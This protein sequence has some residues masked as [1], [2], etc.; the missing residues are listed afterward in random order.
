MTDAAIAL[1]PGA[2]LDRYTIESQ[3]SG[4]GFSIVYVA[5][6]QDGG[7]VAI[8]EYFPYRLAERSSGTQVVVTP[9]NQGAFNAGLNA[10]FA[11]ARVLAEIDHPNV[12]RVLGVFRANGTAYMVMR[13]EQ[14]RTLQE[15]L[16]QLAAE[17]K[18][19]REPSLRQVFSLLLAGLREVHRHRLLHLDIKPANILLRNDGQPVLLD[20]GAT[21][22]AL[23]TGATRLVPV[24][25]PGYAAPEQQGSGEP[26]G[27]WTDIYAIGATLYACMA[28]QPP[29]PAAQRLTN[30]C[31]VP[32]ADQ[33]ADRYSAQLLE[34]VD[35]CLRLPIDRR[36][37]SVHAV[38]KVLSGE[39]LDLV[40]PAWFEEPD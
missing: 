26:L 7:Q 17:G 35:W 36:P 20:F 15:R 16:R 13:H 10:F 3:S 22:N 19:V 11:E 28:G 4:G 18:S 21:R 9:G 25:T 30:D 39:L 33:F 27:P 1:P 37:Q 12:V 23:D 14:G 40:D 8:K 2:S 24:L 29:P 6:D 5:R 31:L 32:A 38:Q 34:V